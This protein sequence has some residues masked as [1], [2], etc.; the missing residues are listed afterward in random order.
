MEK[1]AGKWVVHA[2]KETI[3]SPG[4]NLAGPRHALVAGKT[5]FLASSLKVF[6][7]EISTGLGSLNDEEVW[8]PMQWASPLH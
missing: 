8:S 2:G 5:L 7:E 6:Q 4:V 1:G 3:S